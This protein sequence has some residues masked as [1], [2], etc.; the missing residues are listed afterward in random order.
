MNTFANSECGISSGSKLFVKVKKNT[1]FFENY[2]LTP[3]DMYTFPCLLYQIRRKNP[4]V[5]KRLI[6][7]LHWIGWKVEIRSF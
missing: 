1:L 5:N 4:L 6:M 3:L 2:N 7:K